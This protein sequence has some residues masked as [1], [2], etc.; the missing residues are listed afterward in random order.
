MK[1]KKKSPDQSLT[2]ARGFTDG[3]IDVQYVLE[4][5]SL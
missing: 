1:S 2:R 5:T 4:P 3:E